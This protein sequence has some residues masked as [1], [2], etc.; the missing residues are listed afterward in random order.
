M[1]FFSEKSHYWHN[2]ALI[3]K[4]K[5]VKQKGYNDVSCTPP[6]GHINILKKR[7][8]YAAFS[9]NGGLTLEASIALP[10]F[11]AGIVALVFFLSVMQLQLHIQKALYNQTIEA[12]GN[13]YY[14][15]AANLNDKAQS[16]LEA[17]YIRQ[18]VIKELGEDYLDKTFIVDGSNGLHLNLSS[19]KNNGIIDVA[20]QYKVGVPFDMLGIG[21]IGLV[22]RARCHT[23]IGSTEDTAANKEDMVYMTSSGTVYHLYK[24]CSYILTKTEKV[25]LGELDTLRNNDGSK[26]YACPS[27]CMGQLYDE[28]FVYITGYGTRYHM[29]IDCGNIHSNIFAVKKETAQNKYKLCSKCRERSGQ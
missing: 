1:L 26:Y 22:S 8:P 13:A 18:Q 7:A 2:D 20:I 3:N 28:A 12:A 24:D 6:D 9:I 29:R 4:N 23:W 17:G 14:V 5:V 10:L 15:E 19:E 25:Q 21:K 11:I 27:C 16:M